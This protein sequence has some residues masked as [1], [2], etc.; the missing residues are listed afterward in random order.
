MQRDDKNLE[1]FKEVAGC[2]NVSE[3]HV[4]EFIEA[5]REEFDEDLSPSEASV[6]ITQ[7]VQLY[8]HISRP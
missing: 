4:R 8:L 1:K 3:Q 2:T 7:L 5:Y 6:M